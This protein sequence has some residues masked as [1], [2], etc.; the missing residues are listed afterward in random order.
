MIS[1]LLHNYRALRMSW[2]SNADN[3][4]E[5]FW[6]VGPSAAP[7]KAQRCSASTSFTL[8]ASWPRLKGLGRKWKSA[9]STMSPRATSSE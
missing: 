9:V 8:A 4:R 1:S 7:R 5:M 6:M 2:R 3:Q